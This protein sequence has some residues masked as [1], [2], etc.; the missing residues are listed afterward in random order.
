MRLFFLLL[1]L[2]LIP[3]LAFAQ[4]TPFS[5]F[6]FTPPPEDVSIRYLT[7]IFGV[8]D[9][10]LHGG[11]S[12]LLGTMFGVFNAVILSMGG[13]I[14]MYILIVSLLRTAHEGEV[15][16][17]KWSSMWIPLRVIMG[18]I[19]MLPKATGYSLIQ[20]FIMWMVVQGVGAADSV[21]AGALNYFKRGGILIQR[22]QELKTPEK[23][24]AEFSST[25]VYLVLSAG[26]VLKSEL[27]MYTLRNA[28]V[29]SASTLGVLPPDFTTSLKVQ[30]ASTGMSPPCYHGDPRTECKGNEDSSGVMNFPGKVTY[31]GLSYEGVCGSVTWPFTLVK[32]KDGNSVP[33]TQGGTNYANLGAYDSR[34]VAAQQII[35]D[36][37]AM[38]YG[39][40]QILLPTSTGQSGRDLTPVDLLGGS[41][42]NSA[43]DYLSI[44]RP[45]IRPP[46][47]AL[48]DAVKK[49]LDA[50]AHMGWIMA[51]SYYFTLSQLNNAFIATEIYSDMPQDTYKV[52]Y[53]DN[54]F[55]ASARNALGPNVIVQQVVPATCSSSTL[56]PLDAYICNEYQQAAGQVPPPV[57]VP[58]KPQNTQ[59]T[60]N[61]SNNVWWKTT[62]APPEMLSRWPIPPKHKP[63]SQ[64]WSSGMTQGIKDFFEYVPNQM[65]ALIN[66][67]NE[68]MTAEDQ[69]NADPLIKVSAMGTH[70]IN[71]V[72]WV[73]LTGP[74]WVFG[75][76]FLLGLITCETAGNAITDAVMWFIPMLTAI[77]VM[78]FLAGLMMA[79][80]FPLIPLI[81]FLFAAI[82][83][84]IGVIESMIA[85]PFVALGL[86]IPEGEHEIF[87]PAYHAI[88]LLFNLFVR[89]TLIIFGFIAAAILVHV[90]LW[91]LNL[92]WMTAKST[93]GLGPIITPDVGHVLQP[94][95][96]ILIYMMI[97]WEV[98][99]R[100]FKLIH[101]IPSQVLTWIGG[102]VKQF[103]EAESAAG[104][105]RAVSEKMGAVSSA[106]G[107]L[108][109]GLEKAPK[110]GMKAGQKAKGGKESETEAG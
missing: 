99:D 88:M 9:G 103:G 62:P 98:V 34:S 33:D 66:E 83:W 107:K 20:I 60:S 24:S 82:G 70:M 84:F 52:D 74:I 77:M 26:N 105:A 96:M 71:I 95:A 101:E 67:M 19:A 47:E 53:T 79:Y 69:L 50:S 39:L 22:T 65:S 41:L 48:T 89:P 36:T 15:M 55:P 61:V 12:Q 17:Q 7:S 18:I 13:V 68:L 31:G 49:V 109:E 85:G 92:S 102:G 4:E 42:R 90:G 3:D 75:A 78:M 43:L 100:S 57:P 8:V 28:L 25:N 97:V 38:A 10:V 40:S 73:W 23:P 14:L 56:T 1:L 44:I 93:G 91:L 106:V 11:G 80:Y 5:G 45:A 2:I 63:S 108:G 29:R 21:W 51:G 86:I 6:T 37:Q 76:A 46:N 81:L 58:N 59:P 27:C 35:L 54:R 16:G 64:S 72:E 32:D 94:F 87:G 30:G 110:A 104:V